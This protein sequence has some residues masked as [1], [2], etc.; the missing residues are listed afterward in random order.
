VTRLHFLP[1]GAGNGHRGSPRLDLG[2]ESLVRRALRQRRPRLGLRL[3]DTS[4]Q[5]MSSN[6]VDEENGF[7][8]IPFRYVWPAELDLM[9]RLAGLRLRDRWEDWSK[10]F[11]SPVRFHVSVGDPHI[12]NPAGVLGSDRC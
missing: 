10:T 11:R 3:I 8:S 4:T 12:L 6:Y 9:A 7:R 2:E 1:L 5:S